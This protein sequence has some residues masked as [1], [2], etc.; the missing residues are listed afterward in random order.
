MEFLV[1]VAQDK[2][3]HWA[4]HSQVQNLS[5]FRTAGDFF[6]TSKV[7]CSTKLVAWWVIWQAL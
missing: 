7:I 2:D 5:G 4:P 1:L 6:L 3:R